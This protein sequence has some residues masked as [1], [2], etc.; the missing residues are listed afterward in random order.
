MSPEFDARV[1]V[2]DVSPEFVLLFRIAAA[3][4]NVEMYS[5]A[6]AAYEA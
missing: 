2:C 4:V 1:R 5:K 3:I 6:A